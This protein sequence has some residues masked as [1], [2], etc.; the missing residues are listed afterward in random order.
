MNAERIAEDFV[1]LRFDRLRIAEV[2][3]L[4]RQDSRPG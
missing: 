1:P 3:W 4:G 2:C